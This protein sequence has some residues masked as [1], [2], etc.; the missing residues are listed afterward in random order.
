MTPPQRHP[1]A[2]E[3]QV[4]DRFLCLAYRFAPEPFA[5]RISLLISQRRCAR[6]WADAV[7]AHKAAGG[8]VITH[9]WDGGE[10]QTLVGGGA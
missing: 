3:V 8:V 6:R 9:S 10:T 4:V 7:K 1:G 2:S 5:E